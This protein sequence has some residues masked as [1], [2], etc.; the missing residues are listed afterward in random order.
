MTWQTV[1]LLIP[2]PSALI[3]NDELLVESKVTFVP[4]ITAPLPGATNTSVDELTKSSP[5]PALIVNCPP[6]TVTSSNLF[7]TW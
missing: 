4:E 6:E 7:L 2:N 1:P 3:T 5:V